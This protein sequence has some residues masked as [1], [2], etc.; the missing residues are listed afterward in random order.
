MSD[1]EQ[2][3]PSEDRL[4][5][6]LAARWVLN[7]RTP[8]QHQE[9]YAAFL[10]VIDEEC[11]AAAIIIGL[12]TR[13]FASQHLLPA[14]LEDVASGYEPTAATARLLRRELEHVGDRQPERAQR[15]EGALDRT[16]RAWSHML[17]GI[18]L[19]NAGDIVAI[20]HEDRLKLGH[21]LRTLIHAELPC[22]RLPT[23]EGDL[24]VG[25]VPAVLGLFLTERERGLNGL[26]LDREHTHM[27]DTA[28]CV[29][30]LRNVVTLRGWPELAP[31]VEADL[32]NPAS[33]ADTGDEPDWPHIG[34][35]TGFQDLGLT[36]SDLLPALQAAMNGREVPV[37]GPAA[38]GRRA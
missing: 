30:F 1:H 5:A 21:E 17:Q 33:V 6:M 37:A 27:F 19:A 13:Y 32:S 3:A 29:L 14:W 31:Y 7:G 12:D 15:L 16:G 34:F 22:A 18:V 24:L 35:G 26:I 9:R 11:T 25:R 23:D 36:R 8:R 10:D 28:T 20:F 38:R 4:P 2:V